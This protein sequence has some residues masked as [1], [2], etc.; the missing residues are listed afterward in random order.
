MEPKWAGH[1][2]QSFVSSGEEQT[3]GPCRSPGAGTLGESFSLWC[4]YGGQPSR[5]QKHPGEKVLKWDGK[6][7][8]VQISELWALDLV[9]GGG[10]SL[11]F[12]DFERWLH[13]CFCFSITLKH[14]SKKK[15]H[16]GSP[17]GLFCSLVISLRTLLLLHDFSSL[18]PWRGVRELP[19][20]PS[21]LALVFFLSWAMR[22]FCMRLKNSEA[23]KQLQLV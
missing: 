8:I 1:L 11:V 22:T 19:A 2:N 7:A 18:I 13:F 21:N 23:S 5:Q 10:Q 3:R 16:Y 12:R 6:P 20:F 14:T 9:G 4:S 15:I 17:V